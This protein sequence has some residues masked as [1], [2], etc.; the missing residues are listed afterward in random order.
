MMCIFGRT[1]K[2]SLPSTY[3]KIT[4]HEKSISAVTIGTSAQHQYG[5]NHCV[6]WSGSEKDCI[7][8]EEDEGKYLQVCTQSREAKLE[9][10][11]GSGLV[12]ASGGQSQQL[13]QELGSLATGSSVGSPRIMGKP[14]YSLDFHFLTV[15]RSHRAWHEAY[16]TQQS[17]M[18]ALLN[19]TSPLPGKS[20]F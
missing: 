5:F 9:E 1:C 14:L 17:K 3:S 16:M 15:T 11:P 20:P 2:A 12:P 7:M 19:P 6:Y 10:Q 18:R 13:K 8:N 4:M